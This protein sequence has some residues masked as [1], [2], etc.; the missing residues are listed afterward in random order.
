MLNNKLYEVLKWIALIAIPALV[1]LV[2]TIGGVWGWP[3]LNEITTTISAVGVFLGALIGVSTYA[4][5]RK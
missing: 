4:Y 5:R 3:Y 2:Q 1:V